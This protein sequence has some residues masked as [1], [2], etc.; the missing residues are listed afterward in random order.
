[1]GVGNEVENKTETDRIPLLP[2]LSG[3]HEEEV[4]LLDRWMTRMQVNRHHIYPCGTRGVIIGF[5][6]AD[7][8]KSAETESNDESALPRRYRK[9]D[10]AHRSF[11]LF[12]L[13]VLGTCNSRSHP[14]RTF[15]LPP[16]LSLSWPIADMR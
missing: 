12:S 13:R 1:M 8:E 10:G 9:R 7:L 5:E 3:I 16:P 2:V 6:R 4:L 11:S 14:M 15:S